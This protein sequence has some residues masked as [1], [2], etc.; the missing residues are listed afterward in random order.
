MSSSR[1]DKVTPFYR[2]SINKYL[3][4]LLKG[5]KP[6]FEM[7][8]NHL[9]TDNNKLHTYPC[10]TCLRPRVLCAPSKRLTNLAKLTMN[11]GGFTY[12]PLISTTF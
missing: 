4:T 8:T 12:G 5:K 3:E 11:I 7:L 1:N 9:F 6:Q 10:S 2:K